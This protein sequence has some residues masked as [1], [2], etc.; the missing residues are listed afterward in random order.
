M[1]LISEDKIKQKEKI[2][3]EIDVEIYKQIQTYCQWADIKSTDTFFEKSAL[4]VL[5][6]D[7]DWKKSSTK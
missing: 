6:K 5:T 2:K 1:P 4:Y 7:K 3:V